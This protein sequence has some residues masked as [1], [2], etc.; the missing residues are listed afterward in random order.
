MKPEEQKIAIAKARGWTGIERYRLRDEPDAPW[1][2][3]GRQPDD[4]AGPDTRPWVPDFPNDEAAMRRAVLAAGSGENW[5]VFRHRFVGYLC[6]IV[7][8]G[9]GFIPGQIAWHV[10]VTSPAQM[11]EAFLRTMNLWEEVDEV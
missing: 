3:T 10:A 9:P 8:A 5:M 1:F 11:A 4:W 7:K 6:E 2:I